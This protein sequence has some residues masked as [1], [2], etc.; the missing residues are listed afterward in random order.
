M[1]LRWSR[2][3]GGKTR[4][5]KCVLGCPIRTRNAACARRLNPISISSCGEDTASLTAAVVYVALNLLPESCTNMIKSPHSGYRAR[6]LLLSAQVNCPNFLAILSSL[7]HRSEKSNGRRDCNIFITKH[8]YIS[9][10][11]TVSI[12]QFACNPLNSETKPHYITIHT[13][14]HREH[15]LN[16]KDQL[17]NTMTANNSCLL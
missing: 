13:A 16:Q 6:S 15:S 11:S 1:S 5:Q 7:G 17:V 3:R 8:F 9:I 14:P 12:V 4:D 10:V 2:Q